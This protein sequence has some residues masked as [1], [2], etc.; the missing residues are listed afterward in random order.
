MRTVERSAGTQLNAFEGMYHR[1]G[2]LAAFTG[3]YVLSLSGLPLTG[4]FIGKILLVWDAIRLEAYG[5][6]AALLVCL[7]FSYYLYF[8]L[9]RSMYML[10]GENKPVVPS[11]APTSFGLGAAAVLTVALGLFPGTVLGWFADWLGQSLS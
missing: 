2:W 4:G 5:S 8:P 3:I 10:P 6:A 9:I 7:L 11:A 1:N